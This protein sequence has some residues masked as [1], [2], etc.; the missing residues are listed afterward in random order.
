MNRITEEEITNIRNKADISDIIGRYISIRKQGRNFVGICPFH[1]DH[2]PSMSISPDKQIYKCFV[3]G[4]GGNV[5]TFVQNFEKISF[6]EAVQKVA[7]MVGIQIELAFTK[8]DSFYDDKML[9][10]FAIVEESVRFLNYQLLSKD[11]IEASE[12]LGN[13]GITL[14]SIKHFEIGLDKENQLSSFLLKK[15]YSSK[16]LQDLDL[17]REHNGTSY[18]TFQNRIVFPIHDSLGKPLGFSGRSISSGDQVKYINTKDTVLY[19]KGSILYNYHRAKDSSRKE[20]EVFLV[21]GVFDAIAV[22]T[23]GKQNVVASLGTALTKEQI[24]LLR[25]LSKKIVV[26]YDGDRAGLMASYKAGKLLAQN[27]LNFEF[28]KSLEGLDPDDFRIKKGDDSLLS[29]LAKRAT[30]I[31]FLMEY[32]LIQ[33]DTSNYNDNKKYAQE[34]AAEINNLNDAFD[35]DIYFNKLA[36]TTGF[37]VDILQQTRDKSDIMQSQKITSI[38]TSKQKIKNRCERAEYTIIA[39]LLAN[40]NACVQFQKDL[41]FLFRQNLNKV[42]LLILDY[43]RN[44]DTMDIA[45]LMNVLDDEGRSIVLDIS[46]NDMFP[47]KYDRVV[48]MEAINVVKITIIDEKIKELRKDIAMHEDSQKIAEELIILKKERNKLVNLKEE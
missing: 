46:E 1:D 26:C 32:L 24:R 8:Q 6:P 20:E 36:K 2:N 22:H 28:V 41:G 25:L 33:Y 34:I 42:V 29:T 5:F 18:D 48:L 12:Y 4:A 3:C 15:G 40:K 7:G 44:H 9:R 10:D 37:S 43:Y 16:K 21:E 19:H 45:N 23:A 47:L 17:I 13:R 14:D 39:Q 30:W 11:G 27:H 31:E 35:K 38:G